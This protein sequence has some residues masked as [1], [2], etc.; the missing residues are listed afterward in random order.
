VLARWLALSPPILLCAEPTRGI[1]VAA[2]AAIYHLL[3]RYADAGN[4]VLVVTSD[5][6][7]AIGVADR[8]LVMHGGR[9]AGE[10]PAG[11]SEEEVM[12]MA[13]GHGARPPVQ[14]ASA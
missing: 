4:A 1:D 7:E 12:A 2:K 5:L 9:L 8:L 13:T 6:P 11:A 14:A 10:L 3:R